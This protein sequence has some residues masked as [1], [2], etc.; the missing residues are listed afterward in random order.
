[1][2]ETSEYPYKENTNKRTV[3]FYNYI[4]HEGNIKVSVDTPPPSALWVSEVQN[5]EL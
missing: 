2:T 5:V 4:D 3:R 1:M